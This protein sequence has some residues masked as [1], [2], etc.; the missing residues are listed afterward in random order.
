[1]MKPQD[2]GDSTLTTNWLNVVRFHKDIAARE[3]QGFFELNAKDDDSDRWSSI[4]DFEP[5][6]PDGPWSL[7]MSQIR[8]RSFWLQL[9][10][11]GDESVFIGGP[12]YLSWQ[13]RGRGWSPVWQPLL[14]REVVV[15]P[16]DSEIVL[17]PSLGGQWA[18]SP[19][20]YNILERLSVALDDSHDDLPATLFRKALGKARP[21]E[22]HQAILDALLRV[23]PA[24]EEDLTKDARPGTFTTPP[25]PWVVFRPIDRFGPFTRH[26]MRDY[27]SLERRL[28]SNPEDVGG[29]ALLEN[30]CPGSEEGKTDL[31]PVVPLNDSQQQV[32]RAILRQRPLSVISG[33]PGCGKSQVV[34]S[35]LLNAWAQGLKV[36]FASNN[37]KAVDVVRERLVKFEDTF[38]VAVRA[39]S[40]KNQNINE[41]LDTTLMIARKPFETTRFDRGQ[42]RRERA[43]LQG[44]RRKLEES[45]ETRLPQRIQ[46]AWRA[47]LR[48][49]A[50]HRDLVRELSDRKEGF[51]T[52][53][54]DVR[55]G[56]KPRQLPEALAAT[57]AWLD[58]ATHFQDLVAKDSVHRAEQEAELRKAERARLSIALP[59]GMNADAAGDWSWLQVSAARESLESW[60]G[61]AKSILSTT[62]VANLAAFEWNDDYDFWS[63]EKD[64][65]TWNERGSSLADKIRVAIS[66]LMPTR[67]SERSRKKQEKAKSDVLRDMGIE[68]STTLNQNLDADE[69]RSW[70]G[71]Y[72]E[73]STRPMGFFDFLPWSRTA[74]LKKQMAAVETRLGGVLPF[75]VWEALGPLDD[76]GRSSLAP[77]VEALQEWQAAYK[78]WTQARTKFERDAG[79]FLPLRQSAVRLRLENA[80]AGNSLDDWSDFTDQVIACTHAA[81][82]AAEAWRRRVLQEEAGRSLRALGEAWDS[83][84]YSP[85]LKSWSVGPGTTVVQAIRAATASPSQASA[86]SAVQLIAGGTLVALIEGWRQLVLA[87]HKVVEIRASL[88][89]IP[90]A[91]ERRAQWWAERPREALVIGEPPGSWPGL[92][93]T[94]SQLEVVEHLVEEW[95]AFEETERPELE[96]KARKAASW[97]E[98]QFGKAVKL[99]PDPSSAARAKQ[100][101]ASA[102]GSS[103]WPQDELQRIFDQF[104]SEWLERQILAIDM[105]LE[106]LSF[107]DAKE[108]WL[109]RL[110]EDKSAL[111]AVG[112]VKQSLKQNS[113]RLPDEMHG[114]FEDALR[115]VPV[116]ITTAQAPQAIPLLPGLFD[117]VVIDEASQCTLTKLLPLVYRGRSLAVIGDEHQLPAI[118]TVKRFEER[119]LASK[120]RISAEQLLTLGHAENDVFKAAAGALPTMGSDVLVLDE[121]YRSHPAIIGFSNRNVYRHQLVLRKD[122]TDLCSEYIHAGVHMT[123]VRG[124]AERGARGR[125]W[126]NREEAT[127]VVQLVSELWQQARGDAEIGV[128]TPFRAQKEL[129]KEGLNSRGLSEVFVDTAYGFQGDERDIMVF[130]PVVA[131]GMPDSSARWVAVPPNQINVA[132]TR[133]KDA[134][135]V[136]SDFGYCRTNAPGILKALAR[137]C[138]E[139]HDL[140]LESAAELE[141]FHWMLIEGWQVQSHPKLGGERLSFSLTGSLG[142]KVGV[143]LVEEHDD[144][145]IHS[146]STTMLGHGHTPVV[147]TEQEVFETPHECVAKVRS[148][149]D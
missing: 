61:E 7:D 62:L 45:L 50:Q 41:I 119:A 28:A 5:T 88:D 44:Q 53:A 29:M 21:G 108:R 19:L 144:D 18:L 134:L 79:V 137:Y 110:A 86:Q 31:L 83:L 116:W 10:Q 43:D 55:P 105:K 149:L 75:Q 49:H 131:K 94:E 34:V 37:N 100:V 87:H 73:C 123:D 111:Q 128:V 138:E 20:F 98:D 3:E 8:S 97:A 140:R 72:A 117:I 104:G 80:P 4:D 147:M 42:V 51:S 84:P 67:E 36:L 96:N 40:Q 90:D 132:L 143:L 35:L 26:L 127:A 52:R 25:S 15:Q 76:Q 148:A 23:E 99:I 124:S 115:L 109:Q 114:A 60:T 102:D 13:K 54:R 129:I 39:G 133:A 78:A 146:V 130:S 59:L 30:A 38:P 81:D 12:G 17:E 139:V 47:A 58:R 101:K 145:R 6:E 24:V 121:H 120:H 33:P 106:K 118:P 46:E 95:R 27:E 92:P 122:P 93:D 1:M 56:S 48:G 112:R 136:V 16:G 89:G 32:V 14:Y 2:S 74:Q 11:M 113:G 85:L 77:L 66:D 141:L 91:M 65:R 107:E 135:H 57:R 63:S 22:L 71:A 64:A 126:R 69:L 103:G 125:S 70:K 142:K 82:A 9:S 68:T